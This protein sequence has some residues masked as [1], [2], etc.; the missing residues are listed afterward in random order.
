VASERV[1]PGSDDRDVGAAHDCASGRN[2]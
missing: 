2:A 1:H